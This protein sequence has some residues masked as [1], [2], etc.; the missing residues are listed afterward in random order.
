MEDQVEELAVADLALMF[1]M[2]VEVTLAAA[3]AAAV[4]TTAVQA[5]A[6]V[7]VVYF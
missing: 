1:Q 6:V 3:E 5:A 7:Q 4:L 2:V